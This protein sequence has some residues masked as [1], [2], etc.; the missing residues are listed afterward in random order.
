[1]ILFQ[2]DDTVVIEKDFE[3]FV[4]N[5]KSIG[6]SPEPPFCLGSW[7]IKIVGLYA[8]I[9]YTITLWKSKNGVSLKK[10]IQKHSIHHIAVDPVMRFLQI[11]LE[12]SSKLQA[13]PIPETFISKTFSLRVFCESKLI[14]RFQH[15]LMESVLI[16][17]KSPKFKISQMLFSSTVSKIVFS[18]L[19]VS[20]NK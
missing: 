8:R 10:F 13:V 3:E 19:I 11:T 15:L 7:P 16:T 18:S 4:T 12:K 20:S 6:R 14:S 17:T 5:Q 9:I 1:M 2:D